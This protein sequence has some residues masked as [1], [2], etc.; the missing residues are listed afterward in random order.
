MSMP[1]TFF[2]IPP[3]V[4]DEIAPL[5]IQDTPCITPI[6][7]HPL[8]PTSRMSH[9]TLSA[10]A[11]ASFYS[12]PFSDRFD[13]SSPRRRL[14]QDR[15]GDQ[16]ME[17]EVKQRYVALQ[18]IRRR[19]IWNPNLAEAFATIYIM[20]LEDDGRNWEQ[21]LWAGLPAFI[22]IFMRERL[23]EGASDNHGWPLESELNT[24]A[25]ALFWLTSSRGRCDL[26]LDELASPTLCHI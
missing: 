21:V 5:A 1:G 12:M 20:L 15:L 14:L 18:I 6:T 26:V 9:A 4:I 7:F 3:E 10:D 2:T 24:L 25:I 8:H 19:D 22:P 16:G 11:G 13:A 23:L 17:E